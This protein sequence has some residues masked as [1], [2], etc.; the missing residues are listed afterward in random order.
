MICENTISSG[1]Y[2]M[3]GKTLFDVA[4]FF[5]V[6]MVCLLV[7]ISAELIGRKKK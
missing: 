7:W 4:V 2:F 3:A 1:F 5:A 6:L